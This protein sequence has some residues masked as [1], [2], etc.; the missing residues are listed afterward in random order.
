MPTTTN[1]ASKVRWAFDREKS[2]TRS[3]EVG[4]AGCRFDPADA[5]SKRSLT[6]DSASTFCLPTFKTA[7]R[8]TKE[9]AFIF[10]SYGS[11]LAPK[12]NR[13]GDE[14]VPTNL[15]IK[16]VPDDIAEKLRIRAKANNRSLQGELLGIVQDAVT[17][18]AKLSA[19]DL[20]KL[21]R[22]SGLRS[23]RE[24][25]AAIRAARDAR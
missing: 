18:P 15:S 22:A 2:V 17:P 12:W 20:L 19:A 25:T 14:Q 13:R 5:N 16:N 11:I 23:P 6:L 8:A 4:S 9:A 21:V 7:A 1:D 10:N 24:A 3:P